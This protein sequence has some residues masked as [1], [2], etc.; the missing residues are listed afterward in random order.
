MIW[1]LS[2]GP[3]WIYTIG[4]MALQDPEDW[5]FLL[6]QLSG[7]PI[8]FSQPSTFRRYLRNEE[9]PSER[10]IQ[11]WLNS[12]PQR[13]PLRSL[14][15]LQLS[16]KA[17]IIV[18]KAEILLIGGHQMVFEGYFKNIHGIQMVTYF[19]D[20]IGHC[21]YLQDPLTHLSGEWRATY[22]AVVL[23]QILD[24]LHIYMNQTLQRT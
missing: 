9:E 3:Q 16:V 15:N 1:R 10:Y 18:L 19:S 22:I 8:Q 4:S 11:P 23:P 12:D 6:T 2:S 20:D 24:F 7:I 5:E 17:L 13:A 21:L 14:R